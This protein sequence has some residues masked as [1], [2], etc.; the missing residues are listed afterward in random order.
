MLS[1]VMFILAAYPLKILAYDGS[2]EEVAEEETE[3]QDPET[4]D[5][6]MQ[7][8]NP[9][10]DT[11]YLDGLQQDVYNTWNQAVNANAGIQDLKETASSQDEKL[12]QID[13]KVSGLED[14]ASKDDVKGL[15]N[16]LQ[17]IKQDTGSILSLL[18]SSDDS[19]SDSEDPPPKTLDDV[20]NL[21]YV[22]INSV[23]MGLGLITG[24]YIMRCAFV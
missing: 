21:V 23:W 24:F 11:S 5:P 1:M 14:S 18:N 13:E 6:E 15:E 10:P 3:T 7:E 2:T 4:Q 19:K 22:L 20:Y 8:P 17:E 12:N 16:G 9:D